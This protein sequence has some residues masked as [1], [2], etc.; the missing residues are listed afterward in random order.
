MRKIAIINQKGGTAK[1]TTAVNLAAALASYDRSVLVIDMDPQGNIAT[2]FD[3]VPHKSL[4]HL[5]VEET[6]MPHECIIPV[7]ERID[8]L[9][10]TKTAA[11]AELILTGLPGRERVLSRKLA[12]LSGYDFVL[13]D[14]PPSL[15]LLNQNA[16][17]Y[18][19]E[20]FIPVSMDYLALVGV[21][22]ILEN[23]K[24]VR[25]ILEHPIDVSLVIPT[26]Y[27]G[28]NRKSREV[29]EKLELHFDGK[30]TDPI[31]AN[32]RLAE[33]ASHH[34]TIFEYDPSSYG[35]RD[36]KNLALRVLSESFSSNGSASREAQV[37]QR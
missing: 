30:V 8:I 4:Y 10:S 25:E 5:L 15:N 23:L 12:H 35:A 24:M 1:T 36:Y 32:V 14:C 37:I 16:M 7:R 11:Q 2:W 34:Q 3:I 18:A 27:D 31:R 20:A 28:R 19:T 26:F 13:L 17:V 9:P 29:L 6:T 21:K 33:A 22:Q